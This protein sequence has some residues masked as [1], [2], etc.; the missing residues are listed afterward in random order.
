MRAVV[1]S[2][3]N[4]GWMRSIRKAVTEAGWRGEVKGCFSFPYKAEKKNGAVA[5]VL[6]GMIQKARQEDTR[7][8]RWDK[9]GERAL[10][11]RGGGVQ[12]TCGRMRL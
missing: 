8:K 7:V 10:R 9:G 4:L 11:S 2:S 12:S 5:R 3:L 1:F 6:M